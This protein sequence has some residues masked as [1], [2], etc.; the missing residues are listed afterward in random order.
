VIVKSYSRTKRN[1]DLGPVRLD[2]VAAF[3][4]DQQDRGPISVLD[5]TTQQVNL[6]NDCHA[7]GWAIASEVPPITVDVPPI[8]G[9]S[10]TQCAGVAAAWIRAN[11][12]VWRVRQMLAYM[13]TRSE[14]HRQFLW[15]QPAA[16]AGGALGPETS[17]AHFFGGFAQYRFEA[18]RWTYEHL[19]DDM[20]DLT[21]D[22][23]AL[24]FECNPG[25]GDLCNTVNPPAHHAVISNIKIC[26][27]FW[28]QEEWYRALVLVH[29]PLHHTYVPWNDSGPR[30]GPIQDTHTHGHGN[31]CAGD[32][33][34]NKAYGMD[35]VRHLATYAA[36]DGGT[37]GHRNKAF[38]NN[39]TY[40]WA[41]YE[42]GSSVR[43]G[44]TLYWP[45]Q[46]GGGGAPV[47]TFEP[48][49]SM[50]PPA[51]GNGWEDGI[52]DCQKIGQEYVCP[53]TSGL[54]VHLPDFDLALE[55]L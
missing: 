44:V 12:D 53:N 21:I 40:S 18:I 32:L 46:N 3:A 50:D 22:A 1:G 49:D 36:G 7:Q 55:C 17:M 43:N 34:T 37:C 2:F 6:S 35:E 30:L 19:W 9:C 26:P 31:S 16:G 47:P 51:P 14:E 8:N 48:C 28:T 54:G 15:G 38:R 23:S 11:H 41:A 24:D 33:E 4:A 5:L 45:S 13:D 25:G 39:D 42:I 29:E 20:H 52:N 27:A 10:A